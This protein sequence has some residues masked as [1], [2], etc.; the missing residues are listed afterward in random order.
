LRAEGYIYGPETREDEKIHSSLK[1]YRKL[2]ENEK[3]QN[4]N[5]VQDIPNKLASIGYTMIPARGKELTSEF[6]DEDV[7]LLARMEHERWMQEKLDAGWKYAKETD[8]PKRQHK[9]LVP[10]ENLP[11]DEQEKD[12]I[13][14]RG[15]PQILAK[16]GYT[17]VKLSQI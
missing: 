10:W 13:M 17:M 11:P 4:R 8:K 3:E 1:P 15:I 2:S 14:V 9:L 16:A 6:N 5:N 7:T 12:Y